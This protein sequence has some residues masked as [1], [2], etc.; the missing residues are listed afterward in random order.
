MLPEKCYITNAVPNLTGTI[1]SPFLLALHA[2][3]PLTSMEQRLLPIKELLRAILRDGARPQAFNQFVSV[4]IAIALTHLERKAASGQLSRTLFQ[5]LL[6][7]LAVDCIADLFRLDDNGIPIQMET[8][9]NCVDLD[10]A[11]EEETLIL[12][13]RLVFSKVKHGLFRAYNELDPSLGKILRNI[14]LGINVTGEFVESD[15]FGDTVLTPTRC[16][17]LLNKPM[18][19][20]ESLAQLLAGLPLADDHIPSM[21]SGLSA[22]LR[23]QTEFCRIVPLLP[24]ALTWRD[25][26][27]SRRSIGDDLTQLQDH[28]LWTQDVRKIT[29]DACNTIKA[30]M[31]SRYVGGNGVDQQTFEAYFRAIAESITAD[32]SESTNGD[33][34]FRLLRVEIPALTETDYRSNHRNTME[35]LVKLVRKRAKSD[36][37]KAFI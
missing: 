5:M 7:D 8:Y 21:L 31:K 9:F 30:Q 4:C 18:L 14:K 28:A 23:G 26:L 29:M 13:R 35:Y 20:R 37:S 12:L 15:R 2:L 17:S 24:L 27:S 36:L 33:S 6:R 32:W 22:Y 10:G 19:Q 3:L 1:I 16:D 11:S 34:L 25:Q